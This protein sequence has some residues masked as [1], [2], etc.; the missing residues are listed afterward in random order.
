MMQVLELSSHR[1]L[2]SFSHSA[3]DVAG[4]VVCAKAGAAKTVAKL[5]AIM[6]AMDFMGFLHLLSFSE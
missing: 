4:A 6:V 5:S 2:E 3:C 1:M